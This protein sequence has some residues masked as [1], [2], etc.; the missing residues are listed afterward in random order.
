MSFFNSLRGLFSPRH[1]EMQERRRKARE[2]LDFLLA[3]GLVVKVLMWPA[4]FGGTDEPRNVTYLP[5]ALAERKHAFDAEARR[6]VEAGEEL[7]FKITP[8]YDGDSFVPARLHMEAGTGTEARNEII[9]V[10][11]YRNWADAD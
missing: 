1:R 10:A 8:E 7:H 2:E 3:R 6:R 4:D 11:P 9:E 5:P